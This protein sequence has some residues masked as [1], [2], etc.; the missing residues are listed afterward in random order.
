M[1]NL[2]Q[3]HFFAHDQFA[4]SLNETV[5]VRSSIKLSHVCYALR[6]HGHLVDTK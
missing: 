6:M 1:P 3:L 4:L 5:T 2:L